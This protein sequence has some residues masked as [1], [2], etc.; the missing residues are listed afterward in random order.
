MDKKKDQLSEMNDRNNCNIDNTNADQLFDNFEQV[1]SDKD[2][3]LNNEFK[4]FMPG[5]AEVEYKLLEDSII[6]DG[7]RDAVVVWNGC[8]V[9]GHNRY[10]ICQKHNIPF[11]TTEM[12]FTAM[13]DR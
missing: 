10:E 5:L 11:R 6:K 2:S 9:D 1:L 12:N 3:N 13:G 4:A 7:C 8:V